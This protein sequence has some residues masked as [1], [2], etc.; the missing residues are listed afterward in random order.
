MEEVKIN[1]MQQVFSAFSARY[2]P[3][4]SENE[5]SVLLSTDDI[6]L[7]FDEIITP[8]AAVKRS[9]SE[10]LTNEGYQLTYN[11]MKMIWLLKENL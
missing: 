10:Y 4:N 3:C 5:A 6:L 1:V 8:D 11:G 9:L 7:T 2:S